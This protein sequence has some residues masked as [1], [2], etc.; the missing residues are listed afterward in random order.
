MDG[1]TEVGALNSVVWERRVAAN[2]TSGTSVF[3]TTP[4]YVDYLWVAG[5]GIVDKW[6]SIEGAASTEGCANINTLLTDA[7]LAASADDPLGA[8]LF[9]AYSTVGYVAITPGEYGPIEET[10]RALGLIEEKYCNETV[11]EDNVC[12]STSSG[13][14]VGLST[15]AIVVCAIAAALF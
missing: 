15:L 2:T 10:G 14:A 4:E 3:Y 8:A 12:E 13:T 11:P 6:A 7:F 9:S 1:T 5:A